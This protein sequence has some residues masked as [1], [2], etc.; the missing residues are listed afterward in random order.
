MN[1]TLSSEK[2]LNGVIRRRRDHVFACFVPLLL[3]QV[4]VVGRRLSFHA[5]RRACCR[6][7]LRRFYWHTRRARRMRFL[8]RS[9]GFLAH[10]SVFVTESRLHSLITCRGYVLS[11]RTRGGGHGSLGSATGD[12]RKAF[13]IVYVGYYGFATNRIGTT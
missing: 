1:V 7:G 3:S 5:S 6:A 2:T 11:L 8:S 13:Y 12:G 9:G 4:A 10:K